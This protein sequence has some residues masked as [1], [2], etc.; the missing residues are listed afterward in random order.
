ML[1]NFF[2]FIEEDSIMYNLSVENDQNALNLIRKV[3]NSDEQL[4]LLNLKK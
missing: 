3:Y 2:F 1:L 4:V